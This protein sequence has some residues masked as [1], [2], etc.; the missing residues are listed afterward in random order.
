MLLNN[1]INIRTSQKKPMKPISISYLV[2]LITILNYRPTST[3][4]TKSTRLNNNPTNQIK[5]KINKPINAYNADLLAKWVECSPMVRETAVQSQVEW[6]QR[7]KKWYLMPPCLTPSIIRWG[8]KVK[9][10]NPGNGVTASLT[11][12]CSSDWKGSLRVTID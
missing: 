12:P 7:L 5:S 2:N 1:Y 11:P 4:K 8:S 10:S 6:Y 3:I 9:W